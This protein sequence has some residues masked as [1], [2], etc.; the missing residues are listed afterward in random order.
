[1]N[2]ETERPPRQRDF[3]R[4]IS[5]AIAAASEKD[6]AKTKNLSRGSR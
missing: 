5:R 4:H 2:D 3:P 6:D 1:M